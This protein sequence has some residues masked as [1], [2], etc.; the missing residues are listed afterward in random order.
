MRKQTP[1]FPK[2]GRKTKFGGK[3]E[4]KL[5]H[6]LKPTT[7][8]KFYPDVIL[9]IHSKFFSFLFLENSLTNLQSNSEIS[10]ENFR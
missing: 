7:P 10:I 8:E 1:N 6:N 2:H 4:E 3:K 5:G 9:N